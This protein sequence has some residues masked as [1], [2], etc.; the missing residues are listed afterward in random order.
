MF[1]R[2]IVINIPAYTVRMV[3]FIRLNVILKIYMLN[4]IGAYIYIYKLFCRKKIPEI[5]YPLEWCPEWQA[6]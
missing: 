6:I 3:N 1:Q 2:I 4:T 5:T